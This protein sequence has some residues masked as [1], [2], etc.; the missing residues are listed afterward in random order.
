VELLLLCLCFRPE[1]SSE[2]EILVLR[3]P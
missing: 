1:D 2:V 3:P